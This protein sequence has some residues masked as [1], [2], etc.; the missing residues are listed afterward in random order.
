MWGLDLCRP[1]QLAMVGFCEYGH[2]S[3]SYVKFGQYLDPTSDCQ[4]VANIL[5][6]DDII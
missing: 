1:E 2:E 4:L 6:H 5:T 3:A